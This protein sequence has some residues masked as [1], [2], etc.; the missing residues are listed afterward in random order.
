MGA[1]AGWAGRATIGTAVGWI[2]NALRVAGPALVQPVH[3]LP[4]MGT[5]SVRV[6]LLRPSRFPPAKEA[7]RI[8]WNR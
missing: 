4:V 5:V 8:G 7:A 6:K 2:R 1:W 3:R